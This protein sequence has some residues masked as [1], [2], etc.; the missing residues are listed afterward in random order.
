MKVVILSGV[1]LAPGRDVFPGDV[2]DVT[3][4]EGRALISRGKAKAYV[5]AEAAKKAKDAAK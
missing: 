2:P 5:E 1:C 3:D 4:R